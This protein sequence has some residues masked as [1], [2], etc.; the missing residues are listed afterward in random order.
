MNLK[1]LLQKQWVRYVLAGI[2]G[3]AL[4]TL[5]YPAVSS[6]EEE[7]SKLRKETRTSLEQ[8]ASKFAEEKQ[9]LN[10]SHSLEL[11]SLKQESS[12]REEQLKRKLESLVTENSSLKKKT[13]TTT[14]EII[15]P[16]GTIERRTVSEETLDTVT[17]KVAQIKEESEKKLKEQ[18]DKLSKQHQ[19]EVS[20]LKTSYESKLAESSSKLEQ[21]QKLYESEKQRSLSLEKNAK[22]LGIGAG[23]NS[24]ELYKVHGH[25]NFW[26]PVFIGG[27]V[28]SDGKYKNRAAVSLGLSF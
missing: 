11:N 10:Q 26:G 14:I 15:K 13:K 22:K 25:Y 9:N 2:T 27:H 24:D 12:L 7:M 6:H 20:S 18:E 23:Y 28:D 1:V 5:V 3:A 16:D 19:T 17:E 8:Q 21:I 4:T